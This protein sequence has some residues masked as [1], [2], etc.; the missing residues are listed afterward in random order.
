MESHE[1]LRNAF[2]K[3]SPKAVAADLG[4]SLSLV[5]KWAEKQSEDGSGSRNPLDRLL[6]I[7]ELSGDSGIVEWLC[8]QSGGYFVRNPQSFCDDGY[9]LLP[10]T[11]E[12]IGQFSSL[13][14]KISA[15]ATDHS[16][17]A[18]EAREIREF[19]D[20]L[21]SYAEGFVRCCEEGDYDQMLHIPKPSQGPARYG[22]L[23]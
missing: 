20:K 17:S 6:K 10:A 2:A 4:I 15:A 13:L 8:Q 7:I 5:Y 14:H 1:V 9:Q 11:N 19:W 3:T 18:E 16:I 23:R 22:A 12:I 21:K